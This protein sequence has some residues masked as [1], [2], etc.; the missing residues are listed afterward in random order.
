MIEKNL[1]EQQP[2][3]WPG[4]ENDSLFLKIIIKELSS[5]RQ[6]PVTK[7]WKR[8][9]PGIQSHPDWTFLYMG[10]TK[11]RGRY[12]WSC[13]AAQSLGVRRFSENNGLGPNFGCSI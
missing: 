11:I 2:S 1:C 9:P 6:M 8:A 4:V 5:N 13:D 12:A 7:P 3:S 10:P